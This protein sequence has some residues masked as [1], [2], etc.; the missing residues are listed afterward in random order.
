[1]SDEQTTTSNEF[2]R[3]KGFISG[4]TDER[5]EQKS[6]IAKFFQSQGCVSKTG[7]NAETGI[8]FSPDWDK[9]NNDLES[10]DFIIIADLTD[11]SGN[12]EELAAKLLVPLNKGVQVQPANKEQRK[13]LKWK[14]TWNELLG[15][16]EHYNTVVG[17]LDAE[18]EMLR[19][20][21]KWL[22]QIFPDTES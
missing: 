2:H 21:K 18:K 15:D 1:M 7:I 19:E 9:I 20:L 8:E 12:L 10:G 4:R 17:K 14:K 16:M 11:L 3:Y 5:E 13:S 6:R 22:K